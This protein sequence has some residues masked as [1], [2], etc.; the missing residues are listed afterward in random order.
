MTKKK[1]AMVALAAVAAMGLSGCMKVVSNIVLHDDDTVS[2]ELIF[3]LEKQYAEGMST[4][5]IMSTLGGDTTTSEMVNAT[6]EPYDDGTFT[7]TKITFSDEPL[8][9]GQVDSSGS[10]TREGDTFVYNGDVPDTTSTQDLPGNPVATMSITFPGAVTEHNGSLSGTT[11]T[12][13]MLTQTE[14]PH[15]VGGATGS[16]DDGGVPG[17]GGG[18]N[19]KTLL[20][21][22]LGVVAVGAL[23]YFIARSR[24]SS[25]AA[26][27]MP[28]PAAPAVEAPKKKATDK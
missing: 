22:I 24:K 14:A 28:A 12:W 25:S 17:A 15:A 3:A 27:E 5:E 11:V 19:S 10:L 1:M 9:S 6:S 18:S 21:I 7:G 20:W 8:D 2:G 16:G 4:D 13:D 26:A 23:V